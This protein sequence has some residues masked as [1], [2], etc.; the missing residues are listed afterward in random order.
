M[1][2]SMLKH[3]AACLLGLAALFAAL[4]PATAEKRV[5]LV[6]GNAAYQH[7]PPLRNPSNDATDIAAKLR[8]L[9]FDV[10]EGIDLQKRDM[11]KRVRAFAE[12]LNGADVGLFYYAGHGL[13]VD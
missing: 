10:V 11:E 1:E 6:I 3:F 9:G 2:A 8:G 7:V 5:A 12:A 13:Q 4:T